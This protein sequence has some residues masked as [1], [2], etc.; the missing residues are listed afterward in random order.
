MRNIICAF[1]FLLGI[2]S[3]LSAADWGILMIDLGKDDISQ[4]ILLLTGA[5]GATEPDEI[6]GQECR[7]VPAKPPNLEAGNH[8]YFIVDTTLID[9]KSEEDELWIAIA[10]FDEAE[11]GSTGFL[12]DYDDKGDQYPDQ[13][14]AL[15]LPQ[16]DRTINFTD[17]NEWKIGII[18]VESAE[19]KEQ[20]NGGDFRFHIV[21]YMTGAFY[22]NRVWVSNN[23]LTESDL[24]DKAAV[25]SLSKLATCWG[26]MKEPR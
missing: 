4:G 8:A 12:M 17:T 5:D 10:Y 18:H 15:G 19:F 24:T 2:C 26:G 7:S 1:V 11:P 14:F 21:P 3:P 13:A 9:G 6:G 23:E 20:G 16:A 25:S 22:I